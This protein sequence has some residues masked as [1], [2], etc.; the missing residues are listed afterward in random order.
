M[1]SVGV[2]MSSRTAPGR[3]Q[4]QGRRG[5]PG[6]RSVLAAAH[7]VLGLAVFHALPR[8]PCPSDL[9]SFMNRIPLVLKISFLK[10]QKTGRLS[11]R[12]S[13]FSGGLHEAR[14]RMKGREPGNEQVN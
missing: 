13:P 9:E 14:P 11:P 7:P 12:G 3:H 8:Q 2:G 10:E 1:V 6:G 4:L 5:R